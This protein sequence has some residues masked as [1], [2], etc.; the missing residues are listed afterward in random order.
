MA[1]WITDVEYSDI[2]VAKLNQKHGCT[3]DDVFEALEGDHVSARWDDDPDRGRRLLVRGRTR[4]GR[5]LRVVLY[6]IDLD[7]GTFRLITAF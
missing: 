4:S 1:L 7:A 6:P 5:V 2:V 3:I